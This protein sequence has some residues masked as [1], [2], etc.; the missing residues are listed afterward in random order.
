MRARADYRSVEGRLYGL[1]QPPV[2]R[3]A[4]VH[5]SQSHA[6]D[7]I[8]GAQGTPPREAIPRLDLTIAVRRLPPEDADVIRDH[9]I[10]GVRRRGSERKRAISRLIDLLDADS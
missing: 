10:A 9:Y 1:G 2:G 8:V 7:A 3:P 4:Q 5:L 6:S